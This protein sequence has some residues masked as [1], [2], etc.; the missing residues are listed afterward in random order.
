[1]ADVRVRIDAPAGIVELEGDRD[2][3]SAYLD[4]LLPLVEQA[5]LGKSAGMNA[6][7]EIP[8]ETSKNAEANGVEAGKKKRR[9]TKPAPAGQSCRDRINMLKAD[10]FF[11][12]HRTPSEIVTGLSKKGWTHNINQASAALGSMFN[13]GEIQRTKNDN[14]VGFS[15]FWDR[16]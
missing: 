10:G 16:D 14:S 5:G 1:M 7:V 13:A 4:K 3:V 15:Y 8:L 12:E 11:K 6:S 2:F 9:V